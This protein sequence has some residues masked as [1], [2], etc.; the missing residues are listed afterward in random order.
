M[1]NGSSKTITIDDFDIEVIKN[2]FSYYIRDIEFQISKIENADFYN[3][4]K[5]SDCQSRL[6]S[7]KEQIDNGEKLISSEEPDNPRQLR[8]EIASRE[9]MI[10]Q[11]KTELI[12]LRQELEKTENEN[13]LLSKTLNDN[14]AEVDKLRQKIT[15]AQKLIQKKLDGNEISQKGN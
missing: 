9:E 4:E 6:V 3:F 14:A 10:A 8:D 1:E 11:T 5:L 12:L 15:V 13:S 7:L 2:A